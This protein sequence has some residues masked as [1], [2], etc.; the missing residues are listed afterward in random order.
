MSLQEQIQADLKTAMRA[1]EK[2]RVEVLRMTLAAIKNARMALDKQAFDEAEAR[3]ET[4]TLD[5]TALLTD[6]QV[7][8]VLKKEVRRRQESAEAYRKGN[9]AD[10]VE[11]EEAEAVILSAYLP[12]MLSADELRPLVAEVLAELGSPGPKEMGKVMPVLMQ[13]FKERADGRIIN[14]VARELMNQ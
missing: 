8:D 12:Q 7:L 2:H 10:L 3:G 13:R 11:Q 1:G 9:R 4:I 5:R 14:Q 6:A